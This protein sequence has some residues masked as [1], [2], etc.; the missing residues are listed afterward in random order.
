MGGLLGGLLSG[1]LAAFFG[2][3]FE[4]IR[5]MDI[6]I[7]GLI[8]FVIFK[9]MRGMLGSKQGSMNQN[10]QQPAFGGSAPK[11]EQPNVHFEQPQS[12]TR[13]RFWL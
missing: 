3:A 10:R 9:L 1:L 7:M 11:F 2:G 6:L 4:G 5:F 8:A 13:W 12:G